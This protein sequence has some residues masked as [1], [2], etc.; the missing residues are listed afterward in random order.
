MNN[1]HV[2]EIFAGRSLNDLSADEKNKI[3][4]HIA[5]CLSCARAYRAAVVAESLVQ[6][7]ATA[8]VEPSPF[9][10]TR[11][12]T[13]IRERQTEAFSP[14]TLWQTARALFASLVMVVALLVA[15][16][17]YVGGFNPT[18]EFTEI[19]ASNNI[20]SADWVLLENGDA[21]GGLTDAEVLTTLY[22]STGDYGQ[23]N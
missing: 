3:E 10:K 18:N 2:R 16:N 17:F 7:R 1:Q 21:S 9:F 12:M 23:D 6:A 5:G 14:A 20:Y 15:V 13:A 4:N 11:V 8:A 22:E 19:T